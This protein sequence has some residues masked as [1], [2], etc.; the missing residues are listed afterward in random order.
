MARNKESGAT[1][2]KAKVK[3][4]N[5]ARKK[6]SAKNM[7]E[8]QSR[9]AS[10]QRALK[11]ADPVE[12][13]VGELVFQRTY[14]D[15][16]LLAKE[17]LLLR[18]RWVGSRYMSPVQ[19]TQAW[20]V[21]GTSAVAVP[22]DLEV[23]NLVWSSR[24]GYPAAA[25]YRDF[26]AREEH[27]GVRLWSITERDV[28]VAHKE[29]YDPG[30]AAGQGRAD[31][32]HF[33]EAVRRRLAE[34]RAATGSPGLVV[35]A[36][37]TELF[38]HW[39]HEGPAFVGQAV[40]ALR[41]A[42]VTVTTLEK[43]V[44]AG[45]VAGELD[46]GEGSWGAGK[47]FSVWNGPAVRQIAHENEWLQRRWLDLFE[48]ERSAG[49]LQTRRPDLDQLLTTLFH[50]LSSDWAFLVTRGQSV[51]YARRRCEQH[52]RDF[53]ELAQLV[54]DGRRD[55]ALAQAR[56]LCDRDGAFPWLDARVA[57]P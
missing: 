22:R 13:Q 48:R 36:Y 43:A 54:Q 30:A 12:R 20:W 3:R 42:D 41:A 57:M 47:D 4:P 35:A 34:V 45:H 15:K 21:A 23:T 24:S 19:A 37:D 25:A 16:G 26:H 17:A 9:D 33:G 55:Q 11:S 40:R 7:M 18:T 28:G 1:G 56:R 38:G 52:R 31:V 46:L 50:A 6:A 2:G 10:Y 44:A 49:R 8:A 32:A 53:H 27:T 5:P 39:W 29:P 51:D 14:I